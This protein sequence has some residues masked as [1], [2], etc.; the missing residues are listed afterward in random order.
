MNNIFWK[1]ESVTSIL[2]AKKQ[3]GLPPIRLGG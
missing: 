3:L 2:P 1:F